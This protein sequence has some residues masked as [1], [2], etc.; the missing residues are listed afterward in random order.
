[1]TNFGKLL[2]LKLLFALY[3]KWPLFIKQM[4]DEAKIWSQNWGMEVYFVNIL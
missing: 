4:K 3:K 1:M 2:L